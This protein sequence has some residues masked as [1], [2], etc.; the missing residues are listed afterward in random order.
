MQQLLNFV[1]FVYNNA[2]YPHHIWQ[3]LLVHRLRTASLGTQFLFC[4]AIYWGL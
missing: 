3:E 4:Y 1:L 2:K